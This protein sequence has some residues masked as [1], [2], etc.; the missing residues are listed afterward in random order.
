MSFFH[1]GSASGKDRGEKIKTHKK[2]IKINESTNFKNSEKTF[3]VKLPNNCGQVEKK[4]HRENKK[5]TC[6]HYT[7]IEKS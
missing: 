2:Y 3:Q 7:Y 1:Y 4:K 5:N 6:W